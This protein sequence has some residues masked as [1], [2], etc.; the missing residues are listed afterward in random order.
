MKRKPIVILL[1]AIV[2][3]CAL[4]YVFIPYSIAPQPEQLQIQLVL[5]TVEDTEYENITE[6]VDP[7]ALTQQIAACEAS[8]LPFYQNSYSLDTVRYEINALYGEKPLHFVLGENSF[9][10]ESGPWNHRLRDAQALIDAL[11]AM[12]TA[13]SAA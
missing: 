13:N 9:V 5:R 10:Y 6:K 12:L 4:A 11:D 2:L 3:Y 7:A 8:R 1:G